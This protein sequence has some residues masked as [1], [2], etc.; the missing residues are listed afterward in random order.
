[1]EGDAANPDAYLEASEIYLGGFFEPAEH[2]WLENVVGEEAFEEPGGT[3]DAPE[4]R[5]RGHP[6]LPARL[7]PAAR[8]VSRHVPGGEGH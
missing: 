4:P 3:P 5:P 1:M 2:F 8:R 7:R 6:P